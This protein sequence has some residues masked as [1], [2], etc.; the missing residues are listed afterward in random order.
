MNLGGEMAE[1]KAFWYSVFNCFCFVT[2]VLAFPMKALAHVS[3]F[4]DS[5]I[6]GPMYSQIAEE[7]TT[8]GA[9]YQDMA[10]VITYGES[11]GDK[12]LNVIKIALPSP[13]SAEK[14]LGVVISGATHGNEYLNI[15][16]RLPQAFLS[17]W[18]SIPGLMR[19]LNEGGVLYVVPILN[20]DGYDRNRRYNNRNVDLN[21]DFDLIPA[22]EENFEEPETRQLADFLASEVDSQNV[23]LR[24]TVDYHCCDGSLLYPWSYSRTSLPED[25]LEGHRL[26]GDLMRDTIDSGY[27]YGSTGQ[28]LGYYPRGTS[29]DYYF[30]RYGA[31]AFTFEGAYGRENRNFER[32]LDWWDLI[33]SALVNGRL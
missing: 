8:L 28:V 22:E 6:D 25:S 17:R 26:I 5:G 11:V 10:T 16:D 33:L 23:E 20:P 30:A 24:V 19:F 14:R 27:D 15:A 18:D 9:E 31:L 21:R 29:K 32:H 3:A 12:P 1:V 7:M 4:S 13:V 2:I